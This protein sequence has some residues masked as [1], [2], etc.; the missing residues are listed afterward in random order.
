M[1]RMNP[2]TPV[3]AAEIIKSPHLAAFA[4]ISAKTNIGSLSVRSTFRP[5]FETCPK[6]GRYAMNF[7]DPQGTERWVG[8]C[9][10]C[11]KT[12]AVEKLLEGSAI[13]KR[14]ADCT[15]ENYQASL[16]EQVQVVDTLKSYA[17]K[18]SDV[19]KSAPCLI[20]SGNRGT[21]KNHLITAAAKEIRA[22]G[23]SVLSMKLQEYLDSYWALGDDRVKIK[24]F[25]AGLASVDLFILDEIGRASETTN[26]HNAIFRLLDARYENVKPTALLTNLGKDGLKEKI[27]DEAYDRLAQGKGKFLSFTWESHRRS[28]Q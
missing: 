17:A 10:I 4:N 26:A 25:I 18:F 5:E 1:G 28:A 22:Q 13:P 19:L 8:S 23:Y 16:P 3:A 15:F 24:S 14:F 27:G 6:H 11:N 21:G 2:S 20:L 7:I 9:P 12:R